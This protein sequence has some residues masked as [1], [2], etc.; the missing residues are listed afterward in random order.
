MFVLCRLKYWAVLNITYI[1]DFEYETRRVLI[2][3]QPKVA[4]GWF[5]HEFCFGKY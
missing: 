1:I 4:L 3:F 2:I 5:T